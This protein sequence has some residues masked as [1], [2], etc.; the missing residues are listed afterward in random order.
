[1]RPNLLTLTLLTALVVSAGAWRHLDDQRRQDGLVE[2]TRLARMR[3][4]SEIRLRSALA[5]ADVSEGGW[6][7]T[8]DPAWFRPLPVNPLLPEAERP[9]LEV[10]PPA[11]ER[12]LEPPSIEAGPDDAAWWYNPANGRV[13]ARIP[14]QSTESRTRDLHHSLND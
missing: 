14:S 1:M 10:A 13:C 7:L 6:V 2:S 3:I 5:N 11:H 4:H 9:W 12:L 8:V